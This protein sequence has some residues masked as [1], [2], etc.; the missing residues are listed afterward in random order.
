MNSMG[1]TG[2]SLTPC[3]SA[4]IGRRIQ[5]LFLF[6]C[7]FLYAGTAGA[8]VYPVQANVQLI[9]PYSLYLADYV[10]SGSERLA[11]NVF[12]SD[13]SRP[14]LNVRFR[15][16][17]VGQGIT[18]E[19]KPNYIPPPVA[20]QSGVPLRL[21]STD[22]AEYF[23]PNNLTF[24]GISQRQYEQRGKLPEGVYQFCF[25]VLE[26]NRGLRISNTACATAWLVLN[27][28]P[29]VNLP[30]QN[31]KLKAQ[32]PQNVI[33]Q[34]T[35]R[36][37]GSPNS[38]FQ[39]EYEIRMVEVWP[40]T[41][42]PNDAIL[43]SPPI[44]EETTRNTTYIYGPAETPLEP[45]RR[46]A[47]RIRAKSIAGIDELDLFKNNG[48]SEVFSFVYGD[49]CDLPTGIA[50]G[51]IG[52]T[53][54]DLTWEPLFNHTAFKVRYRQAGT[55]TWYENNVTLPSA[56]FYALKPSTTYEY[57]VAPTCG[58][59]DGTYSALAKVTTAEEPAIAYSCGIPL[60]T[61]NLDPSALAGSL[62]PGDVIRAGDFDVKL[63]TVSGSNGVF[64][65]E[66][67][68]EV[69]Y[70]N[71]ARVKTAF[72]SITVNKEL[73]MVNGFMNVTGA[74]VDVIPQGVKDA[75]DELSE[76]LDAV[77]SAL[78]E[79]EEHLP[80]QTDW[81]SIVP[82]TLIIVSGGILDVSKNND[83]S[84]TVTDRQG[85]TQTLP[86]GT[87][88]ALKDD[89]GNG[90]LIDK[91]G[92]VH[93]T[94]SDMVDK[95]AKREYNLVLKFR[96]APA[97]R[98]G[99]DQNRFNPPADKEVLKDSYRV[100]WKS[101]ASGTSDPVI[102]TL[103]GT[104]IDKSKIR[105]ELGGV[106]VQTPPISGTTT[107]ITVSGNADGSFGDL[108]A[109]YTSS[110]TTKEQ[111][112]GKLKVASYDKLSRSVVIV[113]VGN[114]TLPAGLTEKVITD[115][116]NAIYGQA[117]AE[118]A[119]TIEP[120]IQAGAGDPFDDGES[121]MLS[122]YTSDMKKVIKAYGRLDDDK[123]YLFLVN[124]PKS[125]NGLGYMP[126]GKQ[127]GFIFADNH[128]SKEALARTIAHELG[129]GAFNL[130]HTFKESN[131]T[132]A[133]GSTDN[134]M[135]YPA[136]NKLYKY[137]WD[138]MRYRDIVVGIFEE[139]EEG[140]II[141]TPAIP[142]EF[143]NPDGS[144]TFITPA[145]EYIVIPNGFKKLIFAH[146]VRSLEDYQL[147]LVTGTLYGFVTKDGALYQLSP[148]SNTVELN[149]KG[150][151]DQPAAGSHYT[152]WKNLKMTGY[153]GSN[154]TFKS[155]FSK[156]PSPDKVVMLLPCNESY[157]Y[158][159]VKISGLP[160]YSGSQV[161]LKS[162]YNFPV[163]LEAV[164]KRNSDAAYGKNS[165]G[166]EA[167]KITELEREIVDYH[168]SSSD[169]FVY[170]KMAQVAKLY[171]LVYKQFRYELPRGHLPAFKRRAELNQSFDPSG[172]KEDGL[173]ELRV[174]IE[175]IQ[176]RILK[177]PSIIQNLSSKTDP[178]ALKDVLLAFTEKD[179]K[180]LSV[181]QK[182]T[183]LRRF[184]DLPF[185]VSMDG[186]YETIVNNILKHTLNS[187]QDKELWDSLSNPSYNGLI[188]GLYR[189]IDNEECDQYVDL[190]TALFAKFY[191]SDDAEGS[192]YYFWHTKNAVTR[193]RLHDTYF[194]LWSQ[195]TSG[196]GVT[197][198]VNDLSDENSGD[199]SPFERVTM[200]FF[201]HEP[202]VDDR[203]LL[204]FPA[205][206]VY[207]MVDKQS[208]EDNLK[209]VTLAGNFIGT[210]SAARL[211]VG[212]GSRLLQIIGGIELLN[213]TISII[214]LSE[215]VQKELKKTEAGQDF[216]EAWPYISLGVSLTTIGTDVLNKF[217][218]GYK[219]NQKIFQQLEAKQLAQ[220]ESK[221]DEAE[222]ILS[223][224]AAASRPAGWVEVLDIRSKILLKRPHVLTVEN[225]NSTKA[226]QGTTMRGFTGCHYEKA[227][228]DFATA[229]GG[230]YRI[231]NRIVDQASGVFEGQPVITINGVDYV[232]TNGLKNGAMVQYA[233][234]KYAGTSSFFPASWD[235]A[236]IL[237]EVEHAIANNQGKIPTKPNGNEY[238]GFSTD[239]KVEIHFYLAA[240]GSIPSYFPKMP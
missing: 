145:G 194:E 64:T 239:G 44:L 146:S 170:S 137:Q 17:I 231:E 222:E 169:Y 155:D 65:G 208:T 50:T 63:V 93:K 191:N 91:N 151:A 13:I 227:L 75:M 189:G 86:P 163:D 101:V 48:Y 147:N 216:L 166:E 161:E 174:L 225:L 181:H 228:E 111:V 90:Y 149:V 240:D 142:K 116:L 132:L 141:S 120:A 129:H 177:A 211:I 77:D 234:G 165:L 96:E 230:V 114:A 58:F 162:E 136:G 196:G 5:H 73:R 28:P 103:E 94:T 37:T 238:F 3:F 215:S 144:A 110:D 38:A 60:T 22:L 39:T 43:T 203:I 113:P 133:E 95:L 210:Y 97:S 140:E 233:S 200:A 51:V 178:I 82:D 9:P 179:Y 192:K 26:Y 59:F 31:E 100:A 184:N 68:I 78:N 125:G 164:E 168:C 160:K 7:W 19:T 213:N 40:A 16:K 45:G 176:D 41:R 115:S 2:L 33:L 195:I 122:N 152:L 57:Q 193:G 157:R 105:F 52:S 138:K 224:T 104:G 109:L 74:G 153:R 49:A 207:R 218:G 69:P 135:D 221:V 127:A 55:Q 85:N 36:H 35:P 117:V 158:Y 171:P 229:N 175:Q 212:G 29:M 108:L 72:T 148:N 42:N 1:A 190:L 188:I 92:N 159:E 15:L 89:S 12:L 46:Y 173:I 71:K 54:F 235:E 112:L 14:E 20:L 124:N 6:L 76:T 34:W 197:L 217:V 198:Q 24:Q 139:D 156:V 25:E 204:E 205:I 11:L 143:L 119:V 223:H 183:I 8:Q 32:S 134:L 81:R 87:N 237:D 30:R 220:L 4:R 18:L 186:D 209:A 83:G 150:S 131:F 199:H 102:A 66:G 53:R 84:V 80:A 128:D 121:G 130:H 187:P 236:R 67:V 47:F 106:P 167:Y 107:T 180:N 185:G 172:D 27:D 62:S 214:L 23:N 118:W 98:Y 61:F 21:I 70:L 201:G 182:L 79:I 56:Q 88:Y 123:Y 232:K 226:Y 10:E 219:A 154:G 126:R 206:Y 99:F 202:V